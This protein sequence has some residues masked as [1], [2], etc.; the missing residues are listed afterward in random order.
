MYLGALTVVLLL[1]VILISV[2]VHFSS[3]NEDDLP[4]HTF[5]PPPKGK[6]KYRC[7]DEYRIVFSF[8]YIAWLPLN[9]RRVR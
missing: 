7:L 4:K 1:M 5:Y 9:L 2:T 6:V 3:R 8:T